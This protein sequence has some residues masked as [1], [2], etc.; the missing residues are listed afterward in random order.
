MT[1]RAWLDGLKVGDEVVVLVNDI[2]IGLDV[3][4]QR[5]DESV[6]LSRYFIACRL[7]DG[8]HFGHPFSGKIVKP[9]DQLRAALRALGKESE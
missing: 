9:T 6:I 2:P 5:C 1:D 8:R 7:N 4:Q 3:V